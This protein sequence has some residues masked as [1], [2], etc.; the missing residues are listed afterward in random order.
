[1]TVAISLVLFVPAA[2]V[3]A[4]L[5]LI[6]IG[7]WLVV[8]DSVQQADAILVLGGH[9]PYRAMEAARIYHQGWASE[10]W[11]TRF[12][13]SPEESAAAKIGAEIP[14][15]YVYNR[16][17]LD[18]LGVPADCVRLLQAEPS[19]D[20]ELGSAVS[21]LTGRNLN[22]IIIVTSK[23]HTRRVKIAWKLYAGRQYQGI[24]RYASDDSFA[25][26][27]WWN[28]YARHSVRCA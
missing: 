27:R 22:S 2:I 20:G 11:L 12:Q 15:E 9:L 16:R 13:L 24:V 19:T 6:A 28:H 8:S 1:M 17:I 18:Q 3:A 26:D 7:R 14:Q 21:E 25:P 5:V 10:V 4:R 23:S